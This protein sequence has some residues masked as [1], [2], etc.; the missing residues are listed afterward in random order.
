MIVLKRK[1]EQGEIE[2]LSY[3]SIILGGGGGGSCQSGL[4]AVKASFEIGSPTIIDMEDLDEED[5]MVLTASAVGA[6]AAK[7]QFVKTEDYNRII[8]LIERETGKKPAAYITNEIGGGSTFNAFIQSS[9]TGI[10][11]LDAACNGR[12]HPLGT[13]GAMGLNENKEYMTVQ[14]A[15]G[16]NEKLGNYVE[17]VVKGSV[18]K[19]SSLVRS[20]AVQAGGL[21]VVAR[22]PVSIDYVR[23]N[24]AIGAISKAGKVGSAYLKGNTPL[25]KIEN[26]VSVLNGSIVCRG[27]VEEFT[28]NTENGLDL[29]SFKVSDGRSSFKMYIWNEYMALEKD[30]E[31]IYSFPDLLTTFD[32]ETG[33]PITS[34]D[35]KEGME[36]IIT[37][38]R[39]NNILLGSGMREKSGYKSIEDVTG[40]EM[41]SY[42]SDL[43]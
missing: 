38:V 42:A 10:P 14:T 31:R 24:A 12:A 18:S 15:A 23:K 13:M 36:I 16:G 40:I 1:I 7:E 28:L 19:T 25:E 8:E 34:A 26:A 43:V 4:D 17:I 9:K 32:A 33:I 3:G 41:L 30:E 5:G 39:H 11:M 27:K 6:P 20:A 21:V 29:G 37:G 2:S 22:N 35:V